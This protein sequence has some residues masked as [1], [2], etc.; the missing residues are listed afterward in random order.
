MLSTDRRTFV[1]TAGAGAAAA[2]FMSVAP[3]M[4]L[5]TPSM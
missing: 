2:A 1:R 5:T 4:R 3:A